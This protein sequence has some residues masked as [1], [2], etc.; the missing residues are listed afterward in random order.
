MGM[1]TTRASLCVLARS[2]SASIW[3]LILSM[4]SGLPQEERKAAMREFRTG[5]TR[6]LL[7]TD[8]FARG[9]DVAHVSLVVHYDL[10]RNVENYVCG[11]TP[12]VRCDPN[13]PLI[14]YNTRAVAASM[15]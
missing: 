13:D 15:W 12:A 5:S 6:I 14:L 3:T 2:L 8:I 1:V 4:V 9:I 10:P 7:S 11:L